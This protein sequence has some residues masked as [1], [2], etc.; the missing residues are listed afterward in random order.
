MLIALDP[1]HRKLMQAA[2]SQRL[3]LVEAYGAYRYVLAQ[4][5]RA[6]GIE[7]IDFRWPRDALAYLDRDPGIQLAVIDLRRQINTRPGLAFA[8]MMR[9]RDC[10]ARIALMSAHPDYLELPEAAPFGEILLKLHRM[11]VMVARI[12]QHLGLDASSPGT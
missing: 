4:E 1:C 8:L 2:A 11:S 6:S 9:R 12:R 7:V 3:I 10:K 5:L